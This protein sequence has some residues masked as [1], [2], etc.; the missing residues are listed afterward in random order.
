MANDYNLLPNTFVSFRFWAAVLD[1]R[2]NAG[3]LVDPLRI[4]QPV[5]FQQLDEPRITRNRFYIDVSAP[6]DV[7][8]TRVA[9]AI[10]A[11]GILVFDRFAQSWW[12]LAD[13]DCNKVDFQAT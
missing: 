7:A 12:I 5:R 3:C 9:A 2:D 13:A 8:K 11:G 6:H 4:G 1:Y 10:D